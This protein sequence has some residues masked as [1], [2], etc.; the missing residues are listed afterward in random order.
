MREHGVKRLLF[1]AGG[2]SRPY[3]R[4][5]SPILWILR[6]TLARAYDGQH[7]DNEAVMEYL[8]TEAMDIE[9]MVHRAGI[10][11]DGEAK[12][13]MRRSGTP[14]I[15]TFRDVAAY[16]LKALMDDTAVHTMDSSQYIK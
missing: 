1:Q 13:E 6:H 11:G 8:N 3:G 2:F 16:N 14:S 5:L 4:S 9:W 15:G 12:G 10:G 7:R